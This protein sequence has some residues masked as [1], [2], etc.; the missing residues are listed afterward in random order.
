MKID[1]IGIA[2]K[3]LEDAIKTFEALGFKLEEIEEVEGQKVRVAMLPVGES[4]IEL[5]EATSE[6][7]AIAKFVASRGEGVQH[8][9]INVEDIELALKRAKD[10]GVK[11]IDEKPKIGAGGKKVAFLH[12]KSTHGVLIEFVEG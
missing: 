1:H 4:R 6:D 7:S 10:A 5:L 3:N 9:A 2:V 11:L 12:P 8:I